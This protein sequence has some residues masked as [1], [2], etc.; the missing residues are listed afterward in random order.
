MKLSELAKLT[1]SIIEQGDENLEINGAAGLNIAKEGEITFLANPKYT[2]QVS[3]T[4]A[5][6]IF[7]NEKE[8]IDRKDIAILR[9][10]DPYL[11][12]ARALRLFH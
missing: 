9:T 7:L 1:F 6:A 3:E 5:S 12:Y 4:K 11:A 2:P 8:K 10:P